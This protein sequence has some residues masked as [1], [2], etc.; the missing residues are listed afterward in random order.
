[1]LLVSSATWLLHSICRMP[2][3]CVCDWPTAVASWW[4]WLRRGFDSSG[5]MRLVHCS[6]AG[7]RWVCAPARTSSNR[8]YC[9][10]RRNLSA[11][12]DLLLRRG[13]AS[14][15]M[16]VAFSGAT[17]TW[18]PRRGFS[19]WW[20]F[21]CVERSSQPSASSA[22]DAAGGRVVT[23]S[24][25]YCRKLFTRKLQWAHYATKR[26]LYR[27]TGEFVVTSVLRRN[28]GATVDE[29]VTSATVIRLRRW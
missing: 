12:V 8:Q 17:T 27:T 3:A 28:L 5:L 9:H 23:R 16:Y 6:C 29:L 25:V 2:I 11:P 4:R 15:A 1:M 21:A 22:S 14:C 26:H 20:I 24:A 13:C 18:Q 7:L 19:T 10:F